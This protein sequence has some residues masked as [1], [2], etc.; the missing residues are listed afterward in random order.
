MCSHHVLKWLGLNFLVLIMVVGLTFL[1]ASGKSNYQV[2]SV[3]PTLKKI[4]YRGWSIYNHV[5]RP[6]TRA[7]LNTDQLKG[8]LVQL[9]KRA[10]F[11]HQVYFLVLHRGRRYGWLNARALVTPKVY[12]LPYHYNSQ[13]YPLWAPEAC[14]AASLKTAL[15]VKGLDNGIGLE[16]IVNRMPRSSDAK[17]GFSGNPYRD[18]SGLFYWLNLLKHGFNSV[19]GQTIYPAPLAKYARRYDSSAKN[20]TGAS[21]KALIRE[22]KRGNSVVFV[23]TFQMQ[24][25]PNS[26][27]VLTLVGYRPGYFLVADPYRYP[28]QKHRVFWVSTRKF[29]RIFSSPIRKRRAVVI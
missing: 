14:E 29:M 1:G 23:G 18:N 21:K 13:L 20:I 28:G 27:H 4:A 7:V 16:Y 9:K 15:S 6:N 12:V 8:Q 11:D 2:Q 19:A 3:R 5:N 17:R 25:D 26:Y 10:T 22:V 24:T